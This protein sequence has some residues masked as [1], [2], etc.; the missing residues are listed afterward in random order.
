LLHVF[1]GIRIDRYR[2]AE[3][4]HLPDALQ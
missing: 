2:G 1:L 4:L 3:A